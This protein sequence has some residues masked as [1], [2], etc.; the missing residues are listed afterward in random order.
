MDKGLYSFIW[1]HSKSQQ[2]LVCIL[3]VLSFPFLYATLQVPKLIVN[4]ALADEVA[5]PKT[6]L[7]VDFQQTEY[8][9]V[10]CAG[11]LSLL[12]I[13]GCFLMGVNVSKGLLGERLVRR[14]RFL[15]FERILRFPL[16]HFQKV[17]Q[18]ELSSMI[19]SEVE[20][21][22]E[23]FGEAFASPMFY[24]GTLLTILSFMFAQDPVLGLVSIVLVPIQLWVIPKLQTQVNL[25]R[26]ERIKHVRKLSGRIGETV[27]GAHDIHTLNASGFSLA[28]VSARLWTIFQIRYQIYFKKHFMKFC[29]NFLLALTPLLF[30]LVGGILIIKGDLTLGALVAA[31][32]AYAGLTAP[33]KELLK[34]YQVMSDSRIKYEQLRQQFDVD[35]MMDERL[36]RERPDEPPSL[37]G[38]LVLKNVSYAEDDQ[39][40]ALDAVSFR[41]E[42]G[43]RVAVVAQGASREKLAHILARLIRPTQGRVMI[44]E[45]DLP[46]MLES[47]TGTRIGYAGPEFYIFDGSFADNALIGLKHR[48]PEEEDLDQT[49]RQ[50]IDEAKA[51][52]NS[53]YDPARDWVD[54]E[55][56]DL[57]GADALRNWMLEVFAALE[58]ADILYQSAMS[59]PIDPET[60]PELEV[61]ILK[62]RK[63]FSRQL[64][65]TAELA[66]LVHPF[67]FDHYNGS[68]TVGSNLIFGE[69]VNEEFDVKNLG[70]NRHVYNVLGECGLIGPFEA[71]GIG[72]ARTMVAMFEGV[73]K[74]EL[75]FEQFSFVDAQSLEELKVVI[76]RYD[77]DGIEALTVTERR[78][79][80]SLTCQLKADVHRLGFIT[81]EMQNQI[82]YARKVFWNTLPEDCR[83]LISRYSRD[84]FNPPLNLR[85]NVIM[86]N[87]NLQRPAAEE[88]VDAIIQDVF[89]D[90]E[91][92]EAIVLAGTEAPVGVA[93]SRLSFA[94]RQSLAFARSIMKKPDILVCNDALSAHDKETQNRIR[95]RVCALL[96]ETSVIWISAER[97]PAGEFD[98]VLVLKKGRIEGR[99]IEH[100]DEE[101]TSNADQLLT[102]AREEFGEIPSLE[103][104][105]TVLKRIPLFEHLDPAG[106]KLLAFTSG[107]L[108]LWEGETLF[109]EG[110]IGAAA[111]V[112]L[113][114]EADVLIGHEGRE[115]VVNHV[116]QNELIGEL[117]LL[118]EVPR[119]ATVRATKD[120]TVLEL[121]KDVFLELIEREPRVSAFLARQM[122]GRLAST[123][124]QLRDRDAD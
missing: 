103:E 110:E 86:G 72:V 81:E 106:L 53:P 83:D 28:D 70:E 32:A 108:T 69:A 25:L 5:F 27:S 71:I 90:M 57:S 73:T 36:Q 29:N 34:Y 89:D 22:G 101:T 19:L 10:L 21:L 37:K 121:K 24:G 11:L 116:G 75:L 95:R 91:M 43:Q 113:D 99:I 26:K 9:L 120:L 74:T 68:A 78:R 105:T 84:D 107:L 48:P 96:P 122:S 47:I 54:Y 58:M 6:V 92:R 3:T 30:Y 123:M 67:N 2:I 33:W 98:Q 42:Q 38:P 35:D 66:D 49:R 82:V 1:R 44:G 51:S 60:H 111:Y 7:G 50:Q 59:T 119:S 31:V 104:E 14:L 97:P 40:K 61:A 124:E 4:D 115:T 55:L 94:G 118:S 45:D 80:I 112:I 17:T 64:K 62:A 46:S 93:G 52:G 100:E 8:L 88:R 79:L 56:L 109:K 16:S 12:M 15:L 77:V 39:A 18:G 114:G 20:P 63:E 85:G 117:A 23:F 87:V 41:V 65:S 102:A 76:G 13:N